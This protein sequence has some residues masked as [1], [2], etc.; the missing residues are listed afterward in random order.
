MNEARIAKFRKALIARERE[1]Q[2]RLEHAQGISVAQQAEQQDVGRQRLDIDVSI[3]SLAVEWE[4]LRNIREAL[5][6]MERGTYG[7]CGV[8]D[9]PVG[10]RRL[11]ALPWAPFCVKCQSAMESGDLC[12]SHSPLQLKPAVA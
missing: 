4:L 3:Q 10:I 2:Q 8:C 6:R 12:V 9:G 5:H 7:V 1:L 11:N